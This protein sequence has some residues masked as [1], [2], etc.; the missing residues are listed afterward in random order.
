MARRGSVPSSTAA[1]VF[2]GRS[3]I[4]SWS[5]KYLKPRNLLA[6]LDRRDQGAGVDNSPGE[7]FGGGPGNE[8]FDFFVG[9]QRHGLDEV[10]P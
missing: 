7:F 5:A 4:C 10:P 1:A 6:R 8:N 3:R 2:K 9:D